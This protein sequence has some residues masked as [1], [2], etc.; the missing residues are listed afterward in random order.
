M[1]EYTYVILPLQIAPSVAYDLLGIAPE[2]S[3]ISPDR[4]T[5]R[6]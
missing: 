6:D 1:L 5:D 3:V 2:I 4:W